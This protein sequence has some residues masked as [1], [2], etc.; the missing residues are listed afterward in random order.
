MT[1]H[2]TATTAGA[3]ANV[4]R[5]HGYD[6]LE[7]L[8]AA[9]VAAARGPLFTTDAGTVMPLPMVGIAGTE[10]TGL[11]A[12]FLAALPEEHRQHYNCRNC[13]AFVERF[14]GLVNVN[15]DGR[16]Y[17]VVWDVPEVTLPP[18]FLAAVMRLEEAVVNSKVTGVFLSELETWGVPANVAGPGSKH[19]GQRWTHLSG[20][21]A[22]VWASPLLTAEQKMAE[23]RQAYVMLKQA[24]AEFSADAARQA[25]RVLEADALD[26]GEKTLGVAAWFLALHLA[27]GEKRG[28]QRDNLVWLAVAKA[29]PGFAHVR[30]S[31]IGTLLA[32]IN[33]GLDYE[34][35]RRRWAEKMHPLQYQRPTKEVSEGAVKQANEIMERLGAAGA[36]ERRFAL[37]TDVAQ[38]EAMLWIPGTD[39]E[40]V[41]K[42]VLP[43]GGAFDHLL[44]D[45]A[46]V[47][48]L[49]LP[50]V[51][52]SWEKFRRDVLPK[53]RKIEFQTPQ[54]R[55][56]FYGLVTAVNPDAPPIFQ[57]DGLRAVGESE[58][59]VLLPRNPV[60]WYFYHGGSAPAQWGLDAGKWV[61]VTAVFLNPPFWQKPEQFAHQHEMVMFSL[62][63][64][65]DVNHVRG[66][67]FFPENLRTEFH[68]VRAVM[69]AHAGR[70]TIAGKDAEGQ[71]NGVAFQRGVNQPLV[72]RVTAADGAV[73]WTL[74][75]WE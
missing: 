25:V 2:T 71:A 48:E 3:A 47:K 58:L 33:A 53:A 49:V 68:G 10:V 27:I 24:L 19:A 29:P 9:R 72:F 70:A 45:K 69:E 50:P 73:T 35:I 18:F 36:L 13:R 12:A 63:G 41:L 55:G 16:L 42:A 67:G 43:K 40:E 74:D 56:P 39:R 6:E 22:E 51:E 62:A 44:A 61:E 60:S 34:V 23:R 75:R 4:E 54:G 65:R 64:A 11:Y 38:L 14:G 46:K 32:D 28:R 21:P 30:S 17:S 31:M 20:K 8:V 1:Q 57:W 15:E 26:R 52:T 66:G 5:G 59:P 7:R 37:L